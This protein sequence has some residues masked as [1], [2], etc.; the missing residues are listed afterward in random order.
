MA[1]V[2]VLDFISICL[3]HLYVTGDRSKIGKGR[4]TG[5]VKGIGY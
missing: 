3:C 1:V 2:R 5:K 4:K